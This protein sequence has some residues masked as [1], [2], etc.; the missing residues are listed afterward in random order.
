MPICDNAGRNYF[1]ISKS[2][3]IEGIIF[4]AKIRISLLTNLFDC[5]ILNVT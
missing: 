2:R 3:A 5:V 1:T 4:F